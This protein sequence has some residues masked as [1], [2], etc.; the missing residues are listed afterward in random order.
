MPDPL[1]TTSALSSYLTARSTPHTS[2]AL[3]TGGTANFVYRVTLPDSKTVIYKHA[4]PH[5]S[6]NHNFAFD[7]ARMDYEDRALEILPPLLSQHFKDSRGE[8][9]SVHAVRW[10]FY[11]KENKLLCISDGG[12]L[13]LKIAYTDLA[14]DIPSIGREIGTWIAALHSCSKT[15][16]LSL[17][18]DEDL[19]KNNAVGV[20]IYRHS[21]K[22]VHVA[23]SSYGHDPEF[24]KLI[25]EEYGSRLATENEC[26]CHGD[27]WPGNVLV[28]QE[29]GQGKPELTIVDWEITRRGTSATDIGQ[30]AAE[31]YLLDRFHGNRGLLPAFLTSYA[32]ARAA[33][34]NR[35]WVRRMVVHWGV[36]IAYW[37]T[38]VEWTDHE[39]TGKLVEIGLKTMK[40]VVEGDWEQLR[41][42]E[43][44]KDVAAGWGKF[45]E[46][47]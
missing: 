33:E 4:A 27:F 2:I 44:L 30:F 43:L 7:P 26:V 21:Y 8:E 29:G 32:E 11:D 13:N 1:T 17:E 9:T 47:T 31:A 41:T 25:D 42:S 22:N 37:P 36:H 18:G 14:L 16:S 38:R 10:F 19:E 45:W 24:G 28:R 23:L 3:L 15:T 34:L 46:R 39:G 12:D 5:L 40:A 35:E 20:A 6:S